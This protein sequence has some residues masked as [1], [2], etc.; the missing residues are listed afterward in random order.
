ML[1]KPQNLKGFVL[2]LL[3]NVPILKI[4]CFFLKNETVWITL[5]CYGINHKITKL[6]L[7]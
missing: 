7:F 5:T 1:K 2:G 4:F 3:N 6:D